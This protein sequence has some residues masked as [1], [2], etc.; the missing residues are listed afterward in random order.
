VINLQKTLAKQFGRLKSFLCFK[1]KINLEKGEKKKI[2]IFAP[3][4]G[5]DPHFSAMCIVGKVL[6]EKN[7]DVW[8]T[9]CNSLFDRCP[10]MGAQALPFDISNKTRKSVCSD[11]FKK[12]HAKLSK[13]NLK[14]FDTSKYYKKEDKKILENE[15]KTNDL[16]ETKYKNINFSNLCAFETS[17][18]LKKIILEKNDPETKN[19]L[20]VL[21]KTAL[22]S[23]LLI[24]RLLKEH[25]FDV[26]CYFNDYSIQLG[27]GLAAQK[28]NIERRVISH[29]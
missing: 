5:V 20:N 19:A 24:D 27:A 6:S 11:C 3:E 2:L 23:F 16:F 29:A 12:A 18:A 26:I 8:F 14:Y 7:C 13:Y 21:L 28:N 1:K 22:K 17:V 9:R 10:V 15:L 25:K 4:A